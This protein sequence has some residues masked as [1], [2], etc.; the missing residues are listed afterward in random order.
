MLRARFMSAVP[1]AG[2]LERRLRE[3]TVLNATLR[4]ITSTL[5]LTEILRSVLEHIKHVTAAE[6]LSL[7]LYDRERE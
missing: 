3:V 5:D 4:A 7:L 2:D 6:G 1:G